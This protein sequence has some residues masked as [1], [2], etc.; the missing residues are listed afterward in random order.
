MWLAPIKRQL[1]PTVAAA[2]QRQ[3]QQQQQAGGGGSGGFVDRGA[4]PEAARPYNVL[5][6]RL[7]PGGTH[8][9]GLLLWNYNKNSSDTARGVK[10]MIVLAGDWKENV[11]V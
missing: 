7:A 4:L 11:A 1:S 10:R 5:M 8:V 6:V 2:C 9:A 3:Q